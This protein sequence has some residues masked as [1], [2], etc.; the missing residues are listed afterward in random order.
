MPTTGPRCRER[1]I[2]DLGLI[3][4]LRLDDPGPVA[5]TTETK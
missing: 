3:W 1:Q 2:E 5:L 4:P